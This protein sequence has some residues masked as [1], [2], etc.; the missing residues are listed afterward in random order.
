M[1]MLYICLIKTKGTMTTFTEQQKTQIDNI[2]RENRNDLSERLGEVE[3]G[4]DKWWS[5]KESESNIS[6]L[7]MFGTY[8]EK[9]K[10]AQIQCKSEMTLTF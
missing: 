9:N 2:L 3:N 4:S 6:K 7:L 10:I 8:E 1:Q 5:L